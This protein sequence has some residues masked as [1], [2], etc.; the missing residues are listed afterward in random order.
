[1]SSSHP[2]GVMWMGWVVRV[3]MGKGGRLTHSIRG[4]VY[5]TQ[6]F[7]VWLFIII[8]VIRMPTMH[9]YMKGESTVQCLPNG[10]PHQG[11]LKRHRNLGQVACCL[12]QHRGRG[13]PCP[14]CGWSVCQS[15]L[16]PHL[17]LGTMDPPPPPHESAWA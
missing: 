13:V 11:P 3:Y 6:S 1:M 2:W 15:A 17:W 8:V 16:C 12:S 7:Y 10:P 14:V 5:M 4:C 9:I